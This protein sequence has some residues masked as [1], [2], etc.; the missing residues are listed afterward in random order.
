MTHF[1]HP[2]SDMRTL[3]ADGEIVIDRGDGYYIFGEDGKRYLDATASLWYCNVGHG[4]QAIVDAVSQQMSRLETYSTFG[5]VGNRPV[6]DLADRLAEIAPVP[7]SLS[8][9]TSGGSDSIDTA[10]K[11]SR[12]YFQVIGQTKRQYVLT[13]EK[14]YHGMH[15]SGDQHRRTRVQFRRIRGASSRHPTRF[16]GFGR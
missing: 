11:L 12:R 3:A 9:F 1:W 15:I 14:S 10:V 7:E 2:F 5:D 4:Q 13:R 8:F 16:V 6:I